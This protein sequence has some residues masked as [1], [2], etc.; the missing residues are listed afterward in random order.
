MHLLAKFGLPRFAAVL[1]DTDVFLGRSLIL[2]C[3]I[4]RS[5]FLVT[6]ANLGRS[7]GFLSTLCISWKINGNRHDS[8]NKDF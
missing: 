4:F 7:S 5:A 6:V 1:H 2:S 3:I 8:N